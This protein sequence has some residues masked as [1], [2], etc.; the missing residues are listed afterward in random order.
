VKYDFSSA[1]SNLLNITTG[2]ILEILQKEPNG[3]S[4][5]SAQTD[6]FFSIISY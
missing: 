6:L 1:E 5:F 3:L 4:P 2:E